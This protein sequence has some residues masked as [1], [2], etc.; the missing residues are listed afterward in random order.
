[1]VTGVELITR[2]A[3]LSSYIARQERSGGQAVCAKAE[4]ETLRQQLAELPDLSFS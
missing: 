2:I 3:E 4:R 1:M